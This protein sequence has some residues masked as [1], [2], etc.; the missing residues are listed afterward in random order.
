MSNNGRKL[1]QYLGDLQRISKQAIDLTNVF[2]QTVFVIDSFRADTRP[3]VVDRQYIDVT[4]AQIYNDHQSLTLALNVLDQRLNNFNAQ[5][6]TEQ[7]HMSMLVLGNDYTLWS[8]QYM[9]LVVTPSMGVSSY[10]QNAINN[11]TQ[12]PIRGAVHV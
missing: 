6:L 5:S 9:S 2:N 10:I 12:S 3:L 8:D 11:F 1:I 7:D 4:E